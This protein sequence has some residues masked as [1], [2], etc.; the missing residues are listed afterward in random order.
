M[1]YDVAYLTILEEYVSRNTYNV[2]L[3]WVIFEGH[4]GLF[5]YTRVLYKYE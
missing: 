5:P 3:P 4:S 1:H 2:L